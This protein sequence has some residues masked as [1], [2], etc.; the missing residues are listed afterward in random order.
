[1]FVPVEVRI[2]DD[3]SAIRIVLPNQ[4]VIELRGDLDSQRLIEV[5]AGSLFPRGR[6]GIRRQSIPE[7]RSRPHFE[8]RLADPLRM[9]N[10]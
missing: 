1:M 4:A 2:R 3:L 5:I 7:Y 6:L 10:R 8:S 9:A